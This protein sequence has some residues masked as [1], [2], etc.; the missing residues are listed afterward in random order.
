MNE[1]QA[2]Q[3]VINTFENRFDKNYF[4]TYFLQ[5]LLK[6]FER[7]NFIYQGNFIPD[8]FD[9][10]I[11]SLERIGKY[12]SDNKEIDLLIVNLKRETSLERAR[13]MQ[14]NFISWYLNGSRG[15]K[16]KD[17]ALVAFISPDSED[18]R[19][20]LVKMDYKFEK[21]A[22]DKIKVV[23]QFT[24][25]KRSS[26]LVGINENSHTAQ[27]R[28]L[29][30]LIN[31]EYYPKIEDLEEAFNV[32]VVTKE[33][34]EEYRN[35]FLKTKLILDEIV[36]IDSKVRQEFESKNINSVDFAKKLLGQ[37]TFLY[38]LQKKG[39]FG[40]EKGK[41]WG[42]G[43]KDFLRKLFDKK[44]KDY[45]NFYNEILEPLFYEALRTDRSD[46]DHY[47]S[48][49]NCKLP[50]LNGGLFDPIKDYD[51]VSTNILLPNELFSNLKGTFKDFGD[52]ILDVFDRYNFTVNEEEPL[53]K[54]VALDPELLGKIY[55]KLNA[56]RPDNFDEYLNVL[57]SGK[58]GEE[59]KFNKEHGVYYTPREIVHYICQ[60][61][62][63]NYLVTELSNYCPD[64]EKLREDIEVFVKEADFLQ[65]IEEVSFEIQKSIESNF[66]F[67][68]Q[69]REQDLWYFKFENLQNIKA[70]YQNL[71]G[72]M[73]Q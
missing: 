2:K 15:G 3:I 72:I 24:P 65:E 62:L 9:K 57:N 8:A 17:A 73:P 26:F 32:E 52:G 58:K 12:H 29:Q 25:A 23:Q 37:I 70:N 18:W 71:Y 68:R 10:Y 7:N 60:E 46:V 59:I 34:F 53:E 47:Y 43:S 28:F 50:F 67:N 35:L 11:S 30:I 22:P 61:S 41:Q 51:W 66:I 6:S 54:E 16:L 64:I 69:N 27:S 13:T 19:F 1:D 21:T 5:N 40:V 14:R 45:K 44:F 42:S 48:M 39:W 38:F 33:F 56:I 20:S 55:E 4:T 31:D 36:E 63:I 49:F